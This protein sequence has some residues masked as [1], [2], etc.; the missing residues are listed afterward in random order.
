MN[1]PSG[2]G[3]PCTPL[4]VVAASTLVP[5]SPMMVEEPAA[6]DQRSGFDTLEHA[7]ALFLRCSIPLEHSS[8]A[9]V[10]RSDWMRA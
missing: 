5:A 3:S 2:E 7:G 8:G 4:P 9:P 10:D 6:E 1:L